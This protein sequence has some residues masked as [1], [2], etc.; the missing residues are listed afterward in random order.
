MA[1]TTEA[2]SNGH[3]FGGPGDKTPSHHQTVGLA[4]PLLDWDRQ[5]RPCFLSVQNRVNQNP[6]NPLVKL[7]FRLLFRALL[8]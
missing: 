1:T 8:I 4:S 5:D 2:G 3:Y 7:L 6:G